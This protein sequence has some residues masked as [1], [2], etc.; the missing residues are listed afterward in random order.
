MDQ[1]ELKKVPQKVLIPL[2]YHLN[3][4][5]SCNFYHAHMLHIDFRLF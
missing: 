4:F 1:N 3:F 5:F 2:D